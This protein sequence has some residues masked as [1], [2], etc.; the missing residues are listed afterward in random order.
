MH[1]Q[2]QTVRLVDSLGHCRGPDCVLLHTSCKEK[3]TMSMQPK[4][5]WTASELGLSDSHCSSTVITAG[6]DSC[7]VRCTTCLTPQ[8]P[9]TR[10]QHCSICSGVR[11][12]A[13]RQ[14]LAMADHLTKRKGGCKQL[15]RHIR[16]DMQTDHCSSD[17][18][19]RPYLCQ[20]RTTFVYWPSGTGAAPSEVASHA[21]PA[22]L[23]EL[24]AS[25]HYDGKH[26]SVSDI[27][28]RRHAPAVISH[29]ANLCLTTR[30]LHLQVR[31]RSFCGQAH[32]HVKT[33]CS[34]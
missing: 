10:M 8:P 20:Y 5:F 18:K 31:C 23:Q 19:S 25:N 22:D 34:L 17:T 21:A 11:A 27:P 12:Q 26:M 3:R 7:N 4:V 30:M 16:R 6:R 2:H 28:D 33:A 13:E 32:I 29:G 15:G 14:A 1:K 24:T 9:E